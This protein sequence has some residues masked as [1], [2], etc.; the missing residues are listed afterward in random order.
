VPNNAKMEL[1][2]RGICSKYLDVLVEVIPIGLIQR[3]C[4]ISLLVPLYH[5]VSNERIAHVVHL[6]HYKNEKQFVCDIDFFCN[7]YHPIS[8]FDLVDHVKHGKSLKK[9][10]YILTFDDGY[11][12]MYSVV[13]PLL[14]KKG[15]PAVFFLNTDFIDNRTLGYKNKA[16]IVIDSIFENKNAAEKSRDIL[17]LPMAPF[18]EIKDRILSIKY[19]EA[20]VLDELGKSLGICFDEYLIKNQPYLSRA[21]IQ[22]MIAMGFYF[23]AHSKDHPLYSDLTIQEQVDQTL[24]SIRSIYEEYHLPYSVFAF[25]Y[26]DR[27]ITREYFRM[28][29]DGVDATFG[30]GGILTDSIAAN[31]QRINFENRPKSA[32]YILTRSWMKMQFYRWLHKAIIYR[33]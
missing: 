29:A 26:N 15:V 10:S 24:E 11:S 30:T 4:P 17:K 27:Q 8:I 25:P 28:I 18:Q 7:R 12:Q 31:L 19:G 23:G 1:N 9:N 14:L 13:S 16:S 5:L 21:E 33:D 2:N 6:F 32:K 22:K 3:F 20:S